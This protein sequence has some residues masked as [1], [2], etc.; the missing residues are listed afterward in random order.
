MPENP[1][2]ARED[3]TP[4]PENPLPARENPAPVQGPPTPTPGC[5]TPGT[6]VLVVVDP[7]SSGSVLARR[8]KER[9]GLDAVA[10]LTS[11]TLPPALLATYPREDFAAELRFSTAGE[12]AAE[13]ERL[14]GGRRPDF[15][16]C[17]SEPG[18][19]AYDALAAHWGMRPNAGPSDVRRDKFLMQERL[20]EA[21]V[22]H[23]PHH[24]ASD[25]ESAVA[26][27][28]GSGLAEFVVK[29][30][31]SFAT[32]GV[33]FCATPDEVR[34]ACDRLFGRVD[35]AGE[36]IT[37]L[38]VQER[39]VGPEY[40][41]DSVSLDGA[42]FVVNM[43]RYTKET[44]DGTP[45]YRAMTAVEVGDHPEITDYV[46]RALAALGI[47]NGPAHSELVLTDRGPVLIETGARMHGGLGPTLVEHASTHSL[48]DLALASRVAPEEFL[49]RTRTAPSLHRGVVECFLSSPATGTVTANRVGE[50]CGELDSYLFD[51]CAQA[52]GDPVTKTTDLI[53]SYGRVV[54]SHE[55]PDTLSRDTAHVLSLDRKGELLDVRPGG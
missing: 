44:I 42:P 10:V 2:P 45:V 6:P 7:Y 27:A 25:T 5:P 8:A 11:E 28:E 22:P 18:V 49:E 21:G 16:V 19:E 15:L 14:C 53:T 39:L 30:M 38:L 12:T 20:R 17:G 36:V 51:T 13:V 35:L 52:P 47:E 23:I 33:F 43:F 37:E 48:T 40:V 55:D 34:T 31:R 3:P 32:D 46:A 41:V 9:Y 54:L 50:A 26:W 4:V 1:L 24:K 29:P